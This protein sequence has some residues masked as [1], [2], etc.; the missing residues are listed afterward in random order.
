MN[1][2]GFR[3]LWNKYADAGFRVVAFPCNQFGYQAPGTSDEER[4]YAYSKFGFEFPVMD[5]IEVNGKDADPLYQFLKQ[6]QPVSL[7]N[8]TGYKR[9]GEPGIIEWNYTKFLVDRNGQ[10]VK[11]LKPA[12]DPLEMEKDVQNL[13]LGK[14]VLPEECIMHPGRLV[15]KVEYPSA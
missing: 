14:E 6:A 13:L 7:P 12:F 5:K 10:A 1:Y 3:Y 4:E 8:S 9:P 11:R 15:C 2:P